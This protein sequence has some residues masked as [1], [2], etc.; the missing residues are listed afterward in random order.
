MANLGKG[1]T[2]NQ[3]LIK[4]NLETGWKIFEINKI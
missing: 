1:V 4:S 3:R 2:N